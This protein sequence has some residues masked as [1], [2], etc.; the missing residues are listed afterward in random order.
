M[1]LFK[2]G[3]VSVFLRF[4]CLR[5]FPFNPPPPFFPQPLLSPSRVLFLPFPCSARC[6]TRYRRFMHNSCLSPIFTGDVREYVPAFLLLFFRSLDPLSFGRY[7]PPRFLPRG[8]KRLDGL[9]LSASRES[10]WTWGYFSSY[11]HS[12]GSN[13]LPCPVLK[14][15]GSFP[16][17]PQFLEWL[18][19]HP[20]L[21]RRSSE[22]Y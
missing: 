9:A 15:P 12:F 21:P 2:F 8:L 3:G 17:P 14:C 18:A 10:T 6:G 5:V 20:P 22:S 13:F 7:A 4:C 19:F 11:G 1:C 16:P